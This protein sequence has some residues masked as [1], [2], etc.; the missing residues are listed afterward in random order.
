[1]AATPYARTDDASPGAA[2]A[3]AAAATRGI[4]EVVTAGDIDHRMKTAAVIT[5]READRTVAYRAAPFRTAK[6]R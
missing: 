2:R 1:M 6:L 3:A 4:G 5:E